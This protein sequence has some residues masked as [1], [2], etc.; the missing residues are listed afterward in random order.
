MGETHAFLPKQQ[1]SGMELRHPARHPAS[2]TG[3]RAPRSVEGLL[4]LQRL[5]GNRA[6][7]GLVATRKPVIAVQRYED[8]SQAVRESGGSEKTAAWA[9]TYQR[10]GAGFSQLSEKKL[11]AR[12]EL[13]AESNRQ[14]AA[15]GSF[16]EIVPEPFVA[17]WSYVK[18][19]YAGPPPG[20]REARRPDLGELASAN[21]MEVGARRR[22]LLEAL[23]GT[24]EANSQPQANA[25]KTTA[26]REANVGMREEQAELEKLETPGANDLFLTIRDCH[27]TARLIMG[28]LGVTQKREKVLTRG[29]DGA[30][31]KLEPGPADTYTFATV[32]Q[33]G[34]NALLKHAFRNFGAII[35]QQEHRDDNIERSVAEIAGAAWNYTKAMSV[36]QA[37]Q[38][39]PQLG[40]L[41]NRSFAVNDQARAAVGQA[42]TQVNDENERTASVAGTL[43]KDLWNFHWAGVI[44]ADGDDYVTLQAVADQM[45]TGFTFN[46]WFKV[47]GQGAQ[48]FHTEEK[49]DPHVGSRPLTLAVSAEAP[50]PRV[51]KQLASVGTGIPIRS[52]IIQ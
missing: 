9:K 21:A 5:A 26:A 33:Q 40:P 46:W 31:M 50:P 42:L 7:S 38:A 27:N 41:F 37:I 10:S 51:P 52:N 4:A 45:K 16:L 12:N 32:A 3:L 44:M 17:S 47:Y 2:P 35:A 29:G 13:I 25:I 8:R 22:G 24:L 28:D 23:A 18:V 20:Q 14:L 1:T 30:P 39:H 49:E 34:A 15:A 36:Y 11:V 19:R 43:G 6:V 48:S